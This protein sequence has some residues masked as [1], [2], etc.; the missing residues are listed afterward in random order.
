MTLE[1]SVYV[2]RA[3][4]IYEPQHKVNVHPSAQG[5]IIVELVAGGRTRSLAR[6]GAD[7]QVQERTP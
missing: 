2:A 3:R 7:G 1:Q 5:T 6:V 4:D